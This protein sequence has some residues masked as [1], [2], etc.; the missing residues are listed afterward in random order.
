MGEISEILKEF[1]EP[2]LLDDSYITNELMLYNLWSSFDYERITYLEKTKDI[3]GLPNKNVRLLWL[4]LALFTPGYNSTQQAYYHN[5]LIG[6][7]SAI[8]NPEVRQTAFQYLFEISALNDVAYVN[9]IKAT[10]HHSWQF[11]NYARQLFDTLWIDE[12]RKK[13]IEKVAK[14]LNS[15]DLR[16]LK[17]KLK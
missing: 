6:Y 4:T 10:N 16:Y 15:S 12:E 14:Q 9:L 2:L 11:R 3:V 1:A 13:E 8:Y 7:T 17:T 5:E